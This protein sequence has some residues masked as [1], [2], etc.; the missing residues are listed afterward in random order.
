MRIGDI[1]HMPVVTLTSDW[2]RQDYYP[3]ILKG[4]LLGM[5]SLVTITNEINPFD[6][7]MG[8]FVL[9][10]VFRYYPNGTIHLLAVQAQA[11][12]QMPMAVAFY[13]QQYF[14]SINDGR[15]SL[16]FDSGPEWIRAICTSVHTMAEV[17]AYVKGIRAVVEDKLNV[18]TLPAEMMTEVNPSPVSEENYIMG[19]VIYIDS[20]G[21]AITNVTRALFEKTGR[22]R[23]FRIYIQGPYT[24]VERMWHQYGGVRPGELQALFNSAGLLELCIYLGN[25]AVL[26][27]V[28]LYDEIQ[29]QF[30]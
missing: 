15:F 26:E 13:E 5:A 11:T 29:I 21:N 25:L 23:A 16:L 27:N 6:V 22:G 28:S 2:K 8:V 10:Q 19:Q 20:Y 17:E 1:I 30:Q 4:E 7:R 14:I 24:K 9:R 3:G 12:D 18:M